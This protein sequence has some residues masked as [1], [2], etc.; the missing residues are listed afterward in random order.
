MGLCARLCSYVSARLVQSTGLSLSPTLRV[1]FFPSPRASLLPAGGALAASG[2]SQAA[3]IP[4]GIL[5]AEGHWPCLGMT[6]VSRIEGTGA[7]GSER[8][9]GGRMG[10]AGKGSG[11]MAWAQYTSWFQSQCTVRTLVPS[12]LS[13]RT[14]CLMAFHPGFSL[15]AA[16]FPLQQDC[17]PSFR[18]L[19]RQVSDYSCPTLSP[20]TLLYLFLFPHLW[21]GLPARANVNSMKTEALFCSLLYYQCLEQCLHI[22]DAH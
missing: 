1:A 6:G 4:A 16:P 19:L 17:L 21:F 15:A 2:A 14:V 22:I 9:V 3:L 13:W 20:F 8:L 11:F 7:L 18:S 12:V 10:E 5:M